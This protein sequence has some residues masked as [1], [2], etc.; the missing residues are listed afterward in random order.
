[1]EKNKLLNA[2][3]DSSGTFFGVHT[4]DGRQF[5]AQLVRETPKSIRF[6]DRNRNCET[7]VRKSSIG[8]VT[9][10]GYIIFA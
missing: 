10:R 4:K 8:C 9:T 3:R 5:N 7:L 2:I 6:R 1:M